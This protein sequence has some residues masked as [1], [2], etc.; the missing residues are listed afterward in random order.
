MWERDTREPERNT[1]QRTDKI[2]FQKPPKKL[3]LLALVLVQA[4]EFAPLALQALELVL[5]A[6]PVRELLVLGFVRQLELVG[7]LL[8]AGTCGSAMVI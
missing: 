5:L 8:H 1:W 7:P 2:K 3:R 4:L 6:P